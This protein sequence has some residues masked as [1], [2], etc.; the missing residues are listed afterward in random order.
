M[1]SPM[2]SKYQIF[3]SS[4][5]EDLKDARRVVMEQILN[6]G[7]IPVGMELFQAGNDSQ[8][9]YIK[10]RII[11][12]DYYVL[13][14]GDRYGSC[15]PDGMS[16][17]E[18]EYRFAIEQSIPVASFLLSKEARMKLPRPN[19]EMD[20]VKEGRLE[21]FR[22]LVQSRMVKFWNE[23]FELAAQISSAIPNLIRDF[24]RPGLVP[25]NSLP[26]SPDALRKMTL[27]FSKE[28]APVRLYEI[29][30]DK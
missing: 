2:N 27:R 3:L 24:P 20:P 7:H 16:Y 23:Q 29:L 5:F 14:V 28:P 8:W 1:Q 11:E 18:R 6:L 26:P 19:I 9:D 10:R 22:G 15:L 4:T 30:K 21:Q 13:V 12:C 25:P 17:T